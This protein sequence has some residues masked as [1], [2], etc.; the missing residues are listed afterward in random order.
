[1][2]CFPGVLRFTSC[3]PNGGDRFL[4]LVFAAVLVR[5]AKFRGPFVVGGAHV[6]AAERLAGAGPRRSG[7]N[8]FRFVAAMFQ[9]RAGNR[10]VIEAGDVPQLDCQVRPGLTIGRVENAILCGMLIQA[11]LDVEGLFNPGNR[12]NNVYVH[13]IARGADHL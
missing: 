1:M 11:Q 10:V 5:N 3:P 13:A 2:P 9:R 6:A 8:P 4:E 12:A 7:G